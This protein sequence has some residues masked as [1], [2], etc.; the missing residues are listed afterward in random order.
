[1][2]FTIKSVLGETPKF[3]DLGLSNANTAGKLNSVFASTTRDGGLKN[4]S[5][6]IVSGHGIAEVMEVRVIEVQAYSDYIKSSEFETMNSF[7]GF[8][9]RGVESILIVK[10]IMMSKSIL[11]VKSTLRL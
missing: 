6:W 3:V 2:N 11:I 5:N 10:S 9:I 4:S 1:M 7:S 8:I